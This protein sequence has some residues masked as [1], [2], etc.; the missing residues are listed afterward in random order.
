MDKPVLSS[1]KFGLVDRKVPASLATGHW[2]ELAALGQVKLVVPL[3]LAV[4]LGHESTRWSAAAVL[5]SAS[6]VQAV[7]EL[8]E[9]HP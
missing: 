9:L 3:A 2:T 7:R 8:V 5:A 6:R 1:S 4:E